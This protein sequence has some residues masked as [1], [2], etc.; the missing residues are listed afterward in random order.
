MPL[1]RKE[2]YSTY[3]YKTYKRVDP[4]GG[5]RM[6]KMAMNVLNAIVNDTFQKV[7]REA[8]NLLKRSG[9]MTMSVSAIETATKVILSGE[10]AKYAVVKG[11]RGSGIFPTGRIHRHLKEGLYA[12][13]VSPHAAK[14]M[15]GVLHYI[16]TEILDIAGISMKRS[17]KK[18]LTPRHLQMAIQNDEELYALLGTGTIS[19]APTIRN[20]RRLDITI[21]KR[22]NTQF[23]DVTFEY[24]FDSI[25]SNARIMALYNFLHSVT[26]K[27]F[28]LCWKTGMRKIEIKPIVGLKSC[29][30]P[31]R[32]T[33]LGKIE[34]IDGAVGH[35]QSRTGKSRLVI[36]IDPYTHLKCFVD[37]APFEDFKDMIVMIHDLVSQASTPVKVFTHGL[38]VDWLHVKIQPDPLKRM[39]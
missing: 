24:S 38:D 6:S 20:P 37:E 9:R 31:D 32:K 22:R 33:F 19:T 23:S 21:E 35:F 25:P 2:S 12:S 17:H 34:E 30:R 14:Y 18:T 15:A 10:L 3:I 28:Q 1:R 5:F 39:R 27:K 16:V 4:A 7:A 11:R 8:S 26:M 36:P 29:S 13:R